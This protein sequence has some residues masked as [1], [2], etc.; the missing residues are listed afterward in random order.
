MLPKSVRLMSTSLG[1]AD[2]ESNVRASFATASSQQS[3]GSFARKSYRISLEST[4][5]RSIRSSVSSAPPLDEPFDEKKEAWQ[6]DVPTLPDITGV[7]FSTR[8]KPHASNDS[9]GR[10]FCT[11]GLCKTTAEERGRRSSHQRHV[12]RH[13][14][15]WCCPDCLSQDKVQELLKE[16]GCRCSAA[17]GPDWYHLEF[18]RLQLELDGHESLVRHVKKVLS[19]A[20][21]TRQPN[22]ANHLKSAHSK[23]SRNARGCMI[24]L[25]KFATCGICKDDVLFTDCKTEEA[26]L[27]DAHWQKGHSMNMWFVDNEIW[28]LIC[29]R[30]GVYEA[31]QNFVH[32]DH[33][34]S[35]PD[36]ASWKH[37][38]STDMKL[39]RFALE[40]DFLNDRQIAKLT[41]EKAKF[42]RNVSAS[43]VCYSRANLI[44]ASRYVYS[45]GSNNTDRVTTDGQA[46]SEGLNRTSKN[47]AQK[48]YNHEISSL[49]PESQ[50]SCPPN[51]SQ[52]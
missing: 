40:G 51:E 20:T 37:L 12:Q 22:L 7:P 28:K 47:Q 39:L 36:H 8:A 38:S 3:D 25:R 21:Y 26:H 43:Q 49:R 11:T 24:P 42:F 4:P 1:T 34:S 45:T 50:P 44:G 32:Q 31:W 2:S 33:L 10:Y 14:S 13:W 48:P 35:R 15:W 29:L 27:W 23:D 46:A 18:H 16:I 52:R 19:T 6:S 41:F 5:G 17:I 30:P 9:E